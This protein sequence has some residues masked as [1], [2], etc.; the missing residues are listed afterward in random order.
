L[1]IR[2]WFDTTAQYY[3]GIN[4]ILSLGTSGTYR[5]LALLRA[6]LGDGMQVLDVGCGTGA[7]ADH[8]RRIVSTHGRVVALDPSIHMLHEAHRSRVHDVVQGLGEFLPFADNSFNML[9]MG[10][11]LR[12]V[13]DLHMVFREYKRVLQPGGSVLILEITL[14]TLRTSYLLLKY[15]LKGVIPTMT[16]LLTRNREAQTLM[17][18]HWDTIE[19]CVSPETIMEALR[20]VG[21]EQ[22]KRHVTLGI[23]SEYTARKA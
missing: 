23:F 10:Y 5:R 7:I 16:R 13:M 20:Y 14:P 3:D 9:T 22:V 17:A 1:R 18:Y 8:A 19:Q 15:Y 2:Q 12:H 11:A 6:G 4:Q 21:F